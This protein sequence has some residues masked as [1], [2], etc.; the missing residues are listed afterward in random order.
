MPSVQGRSHIVAWGGA[1]APAKIFFFPL[2]YEEKLIRP[3]QH[4]TA[5][6]PHQFLTNSPT[7]QSKISNTI[8]LKQKKIIC[9]LFYFQAKKKK[10]PKK[11]LN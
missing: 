3:P 9:N 2:A 8:K 5:G 1:V 6:P 4:F 7:P 11:N 10:K